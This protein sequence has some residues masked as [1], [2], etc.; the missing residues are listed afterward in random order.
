[1]MRI[2]ER[3]AHIALRKKRNEDASAGEISRCKL[4]Y[5]TVAFVRDIYVFGCVIR[6]LRK[7]EN[8]R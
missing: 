4:E 3:R 7:R 8:E 2:N 6:I 1:M 5:I